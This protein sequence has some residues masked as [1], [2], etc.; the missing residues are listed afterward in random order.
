[1]K[2]RE[3]VAEL[4]WKLDNGKMD[5]DEP[6]FVLRAQDVTAAHFVYEWAKMA[7]HMNVDHK[8]VEEANNCAN[9]MVTW[10]TKKVPD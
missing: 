9:Y 10:K 4:Q 2:A 7:A 6:V 3:E 8:K 5:P 1:M